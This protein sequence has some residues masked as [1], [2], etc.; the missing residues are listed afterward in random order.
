MNEEY[1]K[2]FW[3]KVIIND[4]CWLWKDRPFKNGYPY[5]QV[6]R[7]GKK[8][9]ASRVSFFIKNKYLPPVVRHTCD[10][11]ICTNPD[12]LIA[13]TQLDNM[14][15]RRVRGRAKNQNTNKTHCIKGHK[16]DEHNTYYS[17]KQRHCRKCAAIRS[18][19]WRKKMNL[20]KAVI[21]D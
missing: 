20:Q 2:K 3:N 15:D 5:I 14:N 12:H 7:K 16:F 10:N 18:A 8:E 19:E 13:G 11:P 1:I 6:G 9:K 21:F 17:S 4:G